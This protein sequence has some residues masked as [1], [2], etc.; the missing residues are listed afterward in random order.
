MKLIAHEEGRS[1]QLISMDE[2]R[3]L[4][5]GV[6]PIEAMAKLISKYQFTTYPKIFEQNAVLK[7]EIG[8]TQVDALQIPILGLEIYSD[9][10]LVS[11]RSTDDSDLVL[12]QFF[13]WTTKEFGLRERMTIVPR[14][15]ISKIVIDI[16]GGFDNLAAPLSVFGAVISSAFGVPTESGLSIVHLQ[17]GPHPPT[18]YPYQTTWQLVRR[19]A[20]PIVPNRYLSTAPLSTVAHYE[21]LENLEK[22]L[23]RA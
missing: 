16:D 2:V 17:A 1:L 7:F 9:G 8:I 10:V 4:R 23:R 6:F 18:P 11:T 12:D 15:Y 22:N 20:E 13:A 3:P 21:F 5:G 14:K 19:I